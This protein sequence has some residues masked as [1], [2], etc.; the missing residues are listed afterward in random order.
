M[1]LLLSALA[2]AGSVEHGFSLGSYGRAQSSFNL[3]GGRGDG[4][5]VVSR[6][7]RL[8]LGSYLELD[9]KWNL[10]ALD[11]D[12]EEQGAFQ[13]LLTPALSGDLFH[14][15]GVFAED[16][17][18]RNLFAQGTFGRF[19]VWAGSRMYRGDDVYLLDFWPLDQ[20][21][22]YGGGGMVR[23]GAAQEGEVALHVGANRLFGDEFQFQRVDEPLP[24]GVGTESVRVL[25]R[26]RLIGSARWTHHLALGDLTLRAKVYGEVHTL[27]SGQRVLDDPVGERGVEELPSDFGSL[28]GAQLTLWGWAPQSFLHLWVRYSTGLAAY[29]ELTIPRHGLSR[30]RRTAPARSFMLALSGNHDTEVFGVQLGTYLSTSADADGLQVDFDDR[31][32][33]VGVVRPQAYVGRFFT[34]GVEVSH[35]LVQ[36][37][38]LNPRT[39]RLDVGQ[40]TKFSVIPA[41]QLGK[42]GFTRPRVQLTYTASVV[43]QGARALFSAN[44]VRLSDGV[45]HY[46]GIGAEWWVN[47]DR[48]VTPQQTR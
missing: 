35:Q 2:F 32:E 23:Y 39:D 41:V 16:L 47:A 21:N 8:E 7:P 40:I 37:R 44:D 25:D 15:D 24:G 29:G 1:L 20:L 18:I 17:A 34:P 11:D 42:G 46:V 31:L 45:Q 10:R 3:R 6:P 28:M 5:S 26:Q 33:W 48:V 43:G 30:D 22:T 12:G 36:P 13:V 19:T 27:P 9:L 4:L 38:G 14:F